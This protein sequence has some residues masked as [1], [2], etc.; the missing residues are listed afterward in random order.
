[1]IKIIPRLCENKRTTY[2][3]M[4]FSRFKKLGLGFDILFEG[5]DTS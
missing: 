2:K 4:K 3:S 5:L 1:M